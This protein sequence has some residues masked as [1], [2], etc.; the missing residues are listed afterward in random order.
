MKGNWLLG[1]GRVRLLTAFTAL[2][3]VLLGWGGAQAAPQ[4]TV[5]CDFCH[6]MPPLDAASGAREP[7]TGAVKGSHQGHAG[8]SVAS[9]LKCHDQSAAHYGSSHRNRAIEMRGNINDSPG[10]ASYSRAF[11]NQS[12]VPPSPLGSCSNVN[13]HFESPTPEWGAAPYRAPA[14]CDKCHSAN[15]A[16]GSHPGRGGKHAGL[17][18]SAC[19]PSHAGFGHATSS[20]NLAVGFGGPSV[21]GG[22]YQGDLSRFLPS[23]SA[24]KSYA[25]CSNLYCHSDGSAVSTGAI[26][27]NSSPAWGGGV[28][29][30][31]TSC[32]GYPPSYGMDQPKSNMHYPHRH[33]SCAFCHYQTTSDGST[34][35]G[36]AHVNGAYDIAPGPFWEPWGGN[37]Y[38]ESQN[39]IGGASCNNISCHFWAH[40]NTNFYWGPRPNLWFDRQNGPGCFEGVLIVGPLSG[41]PPFKYSW[42]FGDG[43]TS[44]TVS[45]PAPGYCSGDNCSVVRHTFPDAQNYN[46][47]V[48]VR[49]ANRHPGTTTAPFTPKPVNYPP[50]VGK[51]VAM[52][53]LSATITDLSSD[54]DH[55]LCAHSGAG[56]VVIDWGD[57]QVL[58]Q[59][60]VLGSAPSNQSFSHSYP[61]TPGNYILQYT[62]YDN[63]GAQVSSNLQFS[64]RYFP[65]EV[66]D[67]GGMQYRLSAAVFPAADW[68][69]AGYLWDFGDG[70]TGSGAV[71]EHQF[72]AAGSY[73]V[74]VMINRSGSLDS[75][76]GTAT[77]LVPGAA[78]VP[79]VAAKSLS[80]S[81]MTVTL[82]DLS[83]D[84][85]YN[86]AGHSGPGS[87]NLGWSGEGGSSIPLNLGATPSN[88]P[89]SHTFGAPGRYCI[90]HGVTDN[91]GDRSNSDAVGV[92]LPGGGPLTASTVAGEVKGADGTPLS[93]VTV[94]LKQNGTALASAT[95]DS[96][97]GFSF[98]ELTAGSCYTVEATQQGS[99]FYP[100]ASTACLH[101]CADTSALQFALS[102]PAQNGPTVTG[103]VSDQSGTPIPYAAVAL[104]LRGV[105]ITFVYSDSGGVYHLQAP[106]DDCY[107]VK[108]S[109]EGY[110]FAAASREVCA[111]QGTLDFT[112]TLA[113]PMSVR[114]TV[115]GLDGKG[116]GAVITLT[117]ANG[118]AVKGYSDAASGAYL[119]T[120][121]AGCYTARPAQ[122]GYAFSPESREVCGAAGETVYNTDFAAQEVVP[123]IEIAG[124]VSIV[125]GQ[126]GSTD[127]L[128]LKKGEET[129]STVAN[130]SD[131][132]YRFP[133]VPA[134]CYS[135]VAQSGSVITRVY[136]PASREVCASADDVDFAG[137]GA[138]LINLSGKVVDEN[139]AGLQAVGVRLKS[140]GGALL[141]STTSKGAAGSYAFYNLAQGCYL[142]EPAEPSFFA[143]ASL[144]VCSTNDKLDFSSRNYLMR[145]KGSVAELGG[146]GVAGV[147]LR[148][149]DAGGSVVGSALTAAGGSYSF[150]RVLHGCYSVE[151]VP[152]G[153]EVLTPP[154]RSVCSENLAL[155][156]FRMAAPASSQ[157]TASALSTTQVK[158]IWSDLSGDESGFRVERCTGEGCA[159]FAQIAQLEPDTVMYDDNQACQG[160]S[161][162]YR[163]KAYRS[164]S[165]ETV[166]QAAQAA[167]PAPQSPVL[168]AS[169]Q[170]ESRVALSWSDPNGDESGFAI[171]R[172]S[173]E[174]CSTFQEIASVGPNVTSYHDD[175]L[176]PG[177]YS[178]RVSALKSAG[179]SW[180]SAPSAA[181]EAGTWPPL[182]SGL[183]PD[184]ASS[185]QTSLTWLD[186]ALAAT[187]YSI[188][189][190]TGAGCAAFAPIAT[191]ERDPFT[192]LALNLDEPA[193][194]GLAGEVMDSSG[195]GNHGSAFNGAR[196]VAQGRRL[197]AGSFDGVDDYLVAAAD[198]SKLYQFSVELWIKPAP[199]NSQK[200]VF[201]WGDSADPA[202]AAPFLQLQRVNSSTVNWIYPYL[203]GGSSNSSYASLTVP[204]E[205]WSHLV[206]TYDGSYLRFYQNGV[207]KQQ[208]SFMATPRQEK[209][210]FALFGAGKGFYSSVP[211]YYNGQIDG[212]AIYAR[213]LSEADVLSRYQLGEDL[214]VC[215][216]TSYRYRVRALNRGLS[217]AGGGCWTRRVPV[218]IAD[219]Q[220]GY[221][222]RLEVPFAAGMQPDFDDLRLYDAANGQELPY[223]LEKKS[224]GDRATVW[225]RTGKANQIQLY[226]GNPQATTVSNSRKTFEAFDDFASPIANDSA[227][228][229]LWRSTTF[230]NYAGITSVTA[231]NG[232]AQFD[233]KYYDNY[234]WPLGSKRAEALD[235]G[236]NNA[237]D[238]QVQVRL[239]SYPV[240]NLT[241]A[242]ISLYAYGSSVGAYTFGRYRNDATGANG[243]RVESLDG[244]NGS[245]LSDTTLPAYLA[246]RKVGSGYSFHLSHDN[247]NWTQLGGTFT[248]LTPE[249]VTLFGKELTND[250]SL[251]SATMD[252]FY[253]RKYTALE[254][255]AALGAPEEL[256]SCLTL[257]WE[258]PYSD[259]V[260]ITTATPGAPG[261]FTLRAYD[262]AIDLN[263]AR[264]TSDETGF[265]IERCQGAGCV[266]F[267]QIA[268]V[269][270]NVTSYSDVGLTLGASYSYRVKA[271]KSATCSWETAYSDTV[272]A[273][274]ALLA[275]ELSATPVNSTQLNLSWLDNSRSETSFSVE[276]CQGEGCDQ[277]T[278]IGTATGNSY[279]DQAACSGTSYSYR[280][281]AASAGFANSGG[282]CWQRRKS[283]TVN[284]FQPD[285]QSYATVSYDPA[286]RADFGDIRFYD[287]VSGRELPYWLVSKTAASA[288][289]FIRT[290]DSS[291]IYM[292]YGN[293]QATSASNGAAVFELFDD[294]SDGSIDAAL[295]SVMPGNGALSESG[296]T[297]NFSYTGSGAND[298]S[299]AKG[300]EAAALRLKTLPAHDFVAAVRLNSYTLAANSHAGIA[301]YGSDSSA[302]LWGAYSGAVN[303]YGLTKLDGVLIGSSVYPTLPQTFAVKKS[304]GSYY[305][306]REGGSCNPSKGTIYNDVPFN[307]LV[308]FGRESGS[309]SL[310]FGMD[311]FYLRKS[312]PLE[313]TVSFGSST[314]QATVCGASWSAPYSNV[315]SATPALPLPP[316]ALAAG[317][318]SPS[319]INLSWSQNSDESGFRIE[320]CAAE[321][322]SDFSEIATVG[323]DV[324]SYSDEGLSGGTSYSYR[325]RGYKSTASCHWLSDYSGTAGATTTLPAPAGLSATPVSAGQVNLAWSDST[326]SEGGFKIERC[327]GA[328]C[329]DFSQIATVGPNLTA[330]PDATVQAGTSYSYRVRA[331]AGNFLN[332]G[333]GCW[334]RKVPIS[335]SSGFQPN[336]QTKL[337]VYYAPSTTPGMTPDFRDIRFFDETSR[338]ELP[339]WLE[340][341]VKDSYGGVRGTVW[342]KTGANNTISMY[343]GNQNAVS[344]SS[345]SKTFELYD[346]FS[347]PAIDSR[348]TQLAGN[349][350]VSAGGALNFV[351]QGAQNNDWTAGGRQGTALL[352]NSLPSGDFFAAVKLNDYALPEQSMA[353]IGVY[354]S[355][356]A[357]YLLGRRWPATGYSGYGNFILQKNDGAVLATASSN[358]PVHYLGVKKIGAQ[359]SFWESSDNASW[360]A[361]GAQYSD[362]ALNGIALFG[363]EAGGS[364]LAFSMGPFYA[365]KIVA[366]EPS[367]VSYWEG[368]AQQVLYCTDA[369]EGPYSNEAYA[370]P[371]N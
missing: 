271:Y 206:V 368:N 50:L 348:W 167:T 322:C 185:T 361:V 292:Y 92:L 277:F 134:G 330:Y 328:G 27:A 198:G 215:S 340:K 81:G 247:A 144:T 317:A 319:R 346:D 7:A 61:D 228:R 59:P 327:A 51:S 31:C 329:S 230:W 194:S 20:R 76:S 278:P 313:P 57:G 178:Y 137:R 255:A 90:E 309:A 243:F 149:K 79:P 35:T 135:V 304:G 126:T 32:H 295:W 159:D 109:K 283:I 12:S 89:Y 251:L 114:G 279:P 192:L 227:S 169:V 239:N 235:A 288:N 286:M 252:D 232:A 180:R 77:V 364:G 270:N 354:G 142:V 122:E 139:G 132:S 347:A 221:Q 203:N 333:G 241:F 133:R 182:F 307:S 316:A 170:A 234:T 16:T 356:T 21:A 312:V 332:S 201:Q 351:Y 323:A 128:V 95:T 196:T 161:Y 321:G 130:A 272:S 302:Y 24:G 105:P 311:Y 84:P 337:T 190:C 166:S 173:G 240:N 138:P 281:S 176:S 219:F 147:A 362:I 2:T 343:F 6:R 67:L 39:D 75:A 187:G 209:K 290:G 117:D 74:K 150:G 298:W 184:S 296:T 294:F 285:Y 303:D 174:G 116:V 260:P 87:I 86:S 231:V 289:V 345:A 96:G 300:R 10:R 338:Q 25:S 48:D 82:T 254:P 124:R 162:S 315:A 359:Y 111:D 208:S 367:S 64:Y 357:S 94:E 34:I 72:P 318:V 199:L 324:T 225:L 28:S 220:P 148:L 38:F 85:D 168:S 30:D 213:T 5:G 266:N 257:A 352:L 264:N 22:S 261:A 197:G 163:V 73:S 293:P 334:T 23:Q 3:L 151:P 60:L 177:L 13:C 71:V 341:T 202:Q 325:V 258:Y 121:P 256:E 101:S 146:G 172:C 366:V 350:S 102:P 9:C 106:S 259:P 18:C 69:G 360:V 237:M 224:D 118:V 131:G 136:T 44:Q 365:R 8:G 14:D 41:T 188:E 37:V 40:P 70:T 189:R 204:D 335:I 250:T 42:D 269:G 344:A 218:Q 276:R 113:A 186:N 33:Y 233:F 45:G 119:A 195:H 326:G 336:Y 371:G 299:L 112:G 164:G 175:G 4:Y 158:L 127:W 120:P 217:N 97:G 331:W 19:H 216:A 66:S 155:N 49:D 268:T 55:D 339:Y 52:Q 15:P 301:V 63:A 145:I 308:L 263:W 267:S 36:S 358:I 248:N 320:R 253:V 287:A 226:Y 98:S 54:P 183:T 125:G 273:T 160:T 47:R 349:G 153:T 291:S 143:P 305:F 46:I 280:V 179:C 152:A 236:V 110:S 265:K 171:E 249:M 245:F 210:R 193:W 140:L 212:A 238:Y 53:G 11:F 107:Q 93:G 246:I 214:S 62:V 108:V 306:C 165:W 211:S 68:S 80:V 141:Q 115:T 91:S 154:S 78:N 123:F 88:Q 369:W 314:E 370:T 355:D 244:S 310:S 200:T 43:S 83:Y 191:V 223:W 1:L 229:Q 129:V 58:D 156:F 205:Q 262:T 284:N 342:I 17:S 26:A 181:A 242:G 29:T 282:G 274:T 353:G 222:T 275:P 104:S 56:R 100:P 99:A 297:L 157:L 207:L 363:K 103:R 65:V